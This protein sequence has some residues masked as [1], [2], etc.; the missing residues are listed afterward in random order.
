MLLGIT[1]RIPRLQQ[2]WTEADSRVN[3][4]KGSH[5]KYDKA[6]GEE[7]NLFIYRNKINELEKTCKGPKGF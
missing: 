2:S 1:E 3:P 4:T 5:S 6:L 7:N